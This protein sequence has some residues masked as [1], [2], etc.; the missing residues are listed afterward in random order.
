MD[1]DRKLFLLR[2][3]GSGSLMQFLA[4]NLEPNSNTNRDMFLFHPVAEVCNYNLEIPKI[5]VILYS[6]FMPI[7]VFV[8]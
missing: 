1:I 3:L 6:S 2:L 4:S 7:V 5:D 8:I